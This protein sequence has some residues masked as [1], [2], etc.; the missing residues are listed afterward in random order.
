MK[1]LCECDVHFFL[2]AGR[3]TAGRAF[4]VRA[5]AFGAV[6]NQLARSCARLFFLVELFDPSERAKKNGD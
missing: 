6:F 4:F 3:M 1:T 5:Q 2:D